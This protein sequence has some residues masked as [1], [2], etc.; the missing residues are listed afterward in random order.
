M[1][2]PEKPQGVDYFID[3]ENYTR[4]FK[5][6]IESED[7]LV[8]IGDTLARY[9]SGKTT[10]LAKLYE[11]ISK[12]NKFHP[13]WMSL[14]LFSS[15]QLNPQV[16]LLDED[17]VEV[18]AQNIVSYYQL[19]SD[20]SE[21]LFGVSTDQPT[22]LRRIA[23]EALE[24]L[25]KKSKL[26]IRVNKTG[27]IAQWQDTLHNVESAR[28]AIRDAKIKQ[29]DFRRAAEKAAEEMTDYFLEEFN[30]AID[31][32]KDR[33]RVIFVDDF[34]WLRNEPMGSWV[35]NQ[36]GEGME[37]T[38]MIVSHTG[39][40]DLNIAKKNKQKNR[41][42]TLRLSNFT[43][44]EVGE[45]LEKRLTEDDQPGEALLQKYPDLVE[46]VYHFTDGHSQTVCLIADLLKYGGIESSIRDIQKANADLRDEPSLDRLT[47]IVR[48]SVKSLSKSVEPKW[49]R[50]AIRLGA[51]LRRYDGQLM[52]ELLKAESKAYRT[53]YR[54]KKN[55]F[56]QTKGID[57]DAD[58]EVTAR[59]LQELDAKQAQEIQNMLERY[60]FVDY[61]HDD[62][63][64]YYAFHH[65]VAEQIQ[66]IMQED[67]SEFRSLHAHVIDYYGKII[68][69]YDE[70]DDA[71]EFVSLHLYEDPHWQ[72]VVA[73][74][75]YHS[76]FLEP[77]EAQ[78]QF[79]RIYIQAFQWWG[80]Y[81]KFP[82]CD[83]LLTQWEATQ[84]ESEDQYPVIGWLR[85]FHS[86]YPLGSPQEKIGASGWQEV[87]QLIDKI[88]DKFKLAEY[89]SGN[90]DPGKLSSAQ[91]QLL[92]NLLELYAACFRFE[93]PNPDF[94]R[95][96]TIYK[97]IVP[98]SASL[99]ESEEDNEFN[100]SYGLAY[101]AEMYMEQGHY[102]KALDAT[103]D[104]MRKLGEN[105]LIY[106]LNS[107]ADY[108][109]ISLCR[110]IAGEVALI[111]GEFDTAAKNFL[112][113]SVFAYVYNFS[114]VPIPPD[115]YTSRW[116]EDMNHDI[117]AAL[118]KAWQS[119]HDDEVIRLVQH[120]Y[121]FY[122]QFMPNPVI[123][124]IRP[125]LDQDKPNVLASKLFLQPVHSDNYDPKD[126]GYQRNLEDNYSFASRLL[127]ANQANT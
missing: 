89:V 20:L 117:S 90:A 54:Q 61:Y 19:L 102:D 58:D 113:A 101:L 27:D 26:D 100:R 5:K 124:E 76:L 122:E 30:A 41:P 4:G 35:L 63:G 85:R 69:G 2:P 111:R 49:L 96:E 43:P 93:R 86:I 10:I 109:V 55:E 121:S 83:R 17:T 84:V 21:S 8:V 99:A 6:L 59:A 33:R 103:I 73:E 44:E 38:V 71:I 123:F 119:T 52:L 66:I 80:F 29:T 42:E 64:S 97:R 36:L 94:E 112:D 56:L 15:F 125:S 22:E 45:Y 106:P 118:I 1:Q 51:I 75:L 23:L 105:D 13:I 110:R 16:S 50:D 47:R 34:C 3:R 28:R 53:T 114:Q 11:E 32:D 126:P 46:D 68:Q 67:M 108:E 78:L 107:D 70:Q 79:A 39:E 115:P 95:A 116:N 74:W 82:F 120:L 40:K 31:R 24:G 65:F 104:S 57:E 18:Y 91:R 87:Q 127:D 98:L 60:S 62:S 9:G 77:E 7:A 72:T 88:I 37:N 81:L 48:A 25:I 92:V 12:E 14:N